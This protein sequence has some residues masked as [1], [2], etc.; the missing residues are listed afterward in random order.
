MGKM[1]EVLTKNNYLIA[2]ILGGV[3]GFVFLLIIIVGIIKNQD[4]KNREEENKTGVQDTSR[5]ITE[6]T[7]DI[8]TNDVVVDNIEINTEETSLV[9]IVEESSDEETTSVFNDEIVKEETTTKTVVNVDKE[10][11]YKNK[12]TISNPTSNEATT[13]NLT[14]T[15]KPTT[16]VRETT[17]VK[18]TTTQQETTTEE[19]TT[20]KKKAKIRLKDCETEFISF[21]ILWR[22]NPTI[23]SIYEESQEQ[24]NP[25]IYQRTFGE[26]WENVTVLPLWNYM[27]DI[28][29]IEG[30]DFSE[31]A[32]EEAEYIRDFHLRKKIN[33]EIIRECDE[34]VANPSKYG[35]GEE[36]ADYLMSYYTEEGSNSIFSPSL[37]DNPEGSIDDKYEGKKKEWC[38]KWCYF[39]KNKQKYRTEFGCFYSKFRCLR[40][41]KEGKYTDVQEIGLGTRYG[42]NGLLGQ[43]AYLFFNYCRWIYDEETDT[44]TIYIVGAH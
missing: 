41:V 27:T 6:T 43:Y 34:W 13:K 36:F 44:T 14:T 24:Y 35:T 25:F 17:T 15:V 42:E 11:T 5:I 18:V 16:T 23:E 3:I 40:I 28:E 20:E 22:H 19:Q 4:E 29:Y 7:E 31:Y 9:E 12:S 30:D 26:K 2:K 10:T 1:K 33:E 32:E 37:R 38:E 8:H 21:K 39:D